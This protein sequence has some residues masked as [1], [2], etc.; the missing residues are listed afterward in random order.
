MKIK[1][2]TLITGTLVL[3]AL[4][5]TGVVVRR[6]FFKP[7]TPLAMSEQKPAFIKDWR[8]DLSK[9]VRMGPAEAPIQ[10][11]EFA[12]FECPFCGSMHKTIKA[13]RERYPTQVAVTFIHFP[14]PNHRFALPAARVAECAGAQ[15]RFEAMHDHLFEEQDGFGLKPWSD[16]A[17]EAQVPD[18]AVFDDCIKHTESLPRVAEGEALGK[19]LDVRGT[20]TLILNGWKLGRPPS[21]QELDAMVKAVLAG[22]SPVS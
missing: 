1:A 16:Y 4:I 11:M 20:P 9:G 19:L 10:M 22:K 15:G 14:L 6:E 13:V 12:D 21:E 17:T 3:C 2:D 18:S 8:T 5:T 7:A